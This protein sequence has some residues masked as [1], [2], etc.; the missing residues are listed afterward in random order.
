MLC[1]LNPFSP[2]LKICLEENI[3]LR[4]SIFY[5]LRH[6]ACTLLS[7]AINIK[8]QFYY[9]LLSEETLPEL[10]LKH[11]TVPTN[12]PQSQNEMVDHLAS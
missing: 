10:F 5:Y 8:Q 2:I 4:A 7:A 6:I 11:T 1:V 9:L 12:T 3:T